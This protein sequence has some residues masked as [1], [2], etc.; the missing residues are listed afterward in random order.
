M[1]KYSSDYKIA[2]IRKYLSHQASLAKLEREYSIDH[3]TIRGWVE[4]TRKHGLAALKVKHIRQAYPLEF[5][6]NVVHF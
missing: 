3:A 2:I 6:L 4:L 5:K 1:T